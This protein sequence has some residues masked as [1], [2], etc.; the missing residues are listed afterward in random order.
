MKMPTTPPTT[1]TVNGWF[2]TIN[3]LPATAA[4]ISSSLAAAYVAA[5]NANPPTATPAQIQAILENFP[6]SSTPP[7]NQVAS[8]V[9]FRTTVADFVLREFQAAWGVVPNATEYSAWVGRI[10]ANPGL[11]SNGGMSMALAGTPEF[12]AE[13]GT[14]SATQPATAGFINQLAANLGVTA[15]AGAM[16]NV[17]LP[18]FQ[19]LQNFV[20]AP[21]II[22]RLDAPIANFQNLLLAGATPSGSLLSQ[23]GPGGTI[24]TLVLTP[25]IDIP[26]AFSTATPGAVFQ[27]FPVVASTGIGN[28]TL[29][30]GD[31]LQDTAGDG[32]LNFTAVGAA[33]PGSVA[34][35]PY[36]VGV[37]LNGIS[38]LNYIGS[39]AVGGEFGGFQGNVT[40]LTVVND[41]GSS[42]GLQL[43][44]VGQGLN[45]PLTNVNIT[46][47]SPAFGAAGAAG[48]PMFSALMAAAAGTSA[49]PS[50]S[51]EPPSQPSQIDAP[52]GV[53]ATG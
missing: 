47:Y 33:V 52:Q 15:G 53:V 10:I 1:A 38:T 42:G 29:N 5:L 40:G 32:T 45:T 34:N 20:E 9:F 50:S 8:D 7:S 13:Y 18:V 30:T 25:N 24:G 4:P 19:V 41:T 14:T 39:F 21:G 3:G 11:E 37:T 49:T 6:F 51:P 36:A 43:G 23:A 17:G 35:S 22:A 46:G 26:P 44:G 31:N 2:Q 28:N 12:F 16:L 27:A 48:T